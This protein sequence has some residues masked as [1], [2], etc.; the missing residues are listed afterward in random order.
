M[1]EFTDAMEELGAATFDRCSVRV[2]YQTVQPISLK[3][4]ERNSIQPP[5][6][7]PAS[8]DNS[9]DPDED[10][11]V[12]EKRSN[13]VPQSQQLRKDVVILGQSRQPQ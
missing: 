5:P 12:T 8:N 7:G 4:F 2:S 13:P 9:S 1:N 6:F 3:K 10:L 11:S